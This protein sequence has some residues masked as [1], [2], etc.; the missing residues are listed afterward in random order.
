LAPQGRLIPTQTLE[1]PVVKLGEAQKAPRHIK[2][3][4]A[5]RQQVATIGIPFV[6]LTAGWK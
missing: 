3:N 1:H 6:G 2:L 4:V 5:G